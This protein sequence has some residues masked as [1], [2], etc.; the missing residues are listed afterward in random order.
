MFYL[1]ITDDILRKITL[2]TTYKIRLY[3]NHHLQNIEQ[4]MTSWEQEAL[5]VMRKLA[6]LRFLSHDRLA[7]CTITKIC[8][9]VYDNLWPGAGNREM[10]LIIYKPERERKREG[11]ARHEGVRV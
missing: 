11:A 9:Y 7:Q 2:S 8:I 3:K 10:V 5:L 6:V 1:S 4:H